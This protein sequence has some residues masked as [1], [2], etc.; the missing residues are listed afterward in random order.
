MAFASRTFF[1][2]PSPPPPPRAMRRRTRT[3]RRSSPSSSASWNLFSSTILL[4][5]LAMSMAARSENSSFAKTALPMFGCSVKKLWNTPRL[6]AQTK[7]KRCGHS[8]A[9][10]MLSSCLPSATTASS[11][12]R[13]ERSDS[14]RFSASAMRRTPPSAALTTF[15]TRASTSPPLHPA[16][17]SL[18]VTSTTW[19]EAR[20]PNLSSR[21]PSNW[22]TAEMP[23]PAPP[24]IKAKCNALAASSFVTDILRRCTSMKF[25]VCLK[26]SLTSAKPTRRS[27]SASRSKA[28]A[29][30]AGDTWS[31]RMSSSDCSE[32][33]SSISSLVW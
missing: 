4:K 21:P 22:L 27:S 24:C 28:A 10:R 12:T 3:S 31:A 25:L 30:G 13:S 19:P 9:P 17:N 11:P 6:P 32:A 7:Q 29:S 18:R 5:I 8:V 26:L 20:T 16:S 1:A 2:A 23:L 15:F 33:I 14:L